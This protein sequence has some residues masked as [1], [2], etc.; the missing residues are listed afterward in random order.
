MGI[1]GG[2]LL[3]N[4]RRYVLSCSAVYICFLFWLDY[5]ALSFP[6]RT[7]SRLLAL[8]LAATDAD[9]IFLTSFAIWKSIPHN[10]DLTTTTIM[11][12]ERDQFSKDYVHNYE[13]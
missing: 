1:A 3:S 9:R 12:T 4:I 11:H 2:M 13:N 8:R 5:C 6:S 10:V 7:V